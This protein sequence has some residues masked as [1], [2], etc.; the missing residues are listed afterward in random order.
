[1]WHVP[2]LAT[3]VARRYSRRTGRSIDG[4]L[5]LA[6]GLAEAISDLGE[7]LGANHT[8]GQDIAWTLGCLRR[9]SDADLAAELRRVQT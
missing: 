1:M 9:W 4:E 3:S 5:I 2:E 7:L 6:C 8:D